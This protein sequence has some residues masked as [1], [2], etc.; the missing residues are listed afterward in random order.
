[1][2]SSSCVFSSMDAEEYKS[3]NVSATKFPSPHVSYD[4]EEGD[5]ADDVV[6]DDLRSV[7]EV[8]MSE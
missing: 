8:I 6:A 1:M 2:S 3:V 7:E 4:E 5:D